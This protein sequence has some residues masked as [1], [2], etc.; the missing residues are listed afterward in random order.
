MHN[1]VDLA[2]NIGDRVNAYK[3][4]TVI[5]SGWDNNG[6]GNYIKIDH[7]NGVVSTYMH[8]NKIYVKNGD[9]VSVGDKIGEVGNTGIS[10]GPH[11]DFRICVN[12]IYVNPM[13]YIK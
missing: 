7:G 2:G 8:L 6:G 13:N 3:S 11:L 9:S 5:Q 4:G 1:G 10:T 12:G